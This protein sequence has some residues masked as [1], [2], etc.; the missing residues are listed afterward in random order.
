MHIPGREKTRL[1]FFL[2]FLFLTYIFLHQDCIAHAVAHHKVIHLWYMGKVAGHPDPIS[3]INMRMREA[4]E[5]RKWHPDNAIHSWK[6]IP[7]TRPSV[8]VA[9][10][11]GQFSLVPPSKH[12][13][14][15]HSWALPY[16][17]EVAPHGSQHVP[18]LLLDPLG[19]GGYG[20]EGEVEL[21][22]SSYRWGEEGSGGHLLYMAFDNGLLVVVLLVLV[23][24]TKVMGAFHGPYLKFFLYLWGLSKPTCRQS[25]LI[26]H[27]AFIVTFEL[28]DSL[29]L[30]NT[31]GIS[32]LFLHS[33]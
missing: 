8:H 30:A 2:F 33:I 18:H 3:T 4:R 16:V 9:P 17:L 20:D 26:F 29:N 23:F 11:D 27:K 5:Q 28:S 22:D 1:F 7:T 10:K 31:N 6:P 32:S 21:W 15:S 12:V 24:I 25:C 13:L 14:I 19:G